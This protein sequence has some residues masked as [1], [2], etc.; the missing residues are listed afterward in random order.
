MTEEARQANANEA[1]KAGAG[2]FR[3]LSGKLLLLTIVFVMLAEVLIF[4]PSVA[5]MRIRWLE[6]RLNTAA[7]AAVVVDGLQ[8]VELPRSVQK[9]TLMATGTKAI[10]IR[11]KDASRMIAL[12]DMPLEIE[13]EYDVA[14]STAVAAI[15]DAFDTLLFGGDRVIRVYGP[16]GESDA[17]IELL[18]KDASLRKAM[19]VYSRNVFV[20]SL[21]ISLITAALIFL[22]INRML[23]TPIR[24]MTA[25]MQE[26]SNDP[27]DPGRVLVPPEG[28]DELAVAGQHLASMQRELQKTLKQQK[29]LAELGLAVSKINHDMRNI[30]SS[31]QLISDR[32][33]DVDDPV[34]K[35]FAPTLLRTIDRAVGYTREVLSYGRTTE[36]EP[37]RRF[38][39]L[40]PLV[41]DV[42]ELLAIDPQSGIDFQ[43]QMQDDLEVDADSEQLFRVVHNIC[44][45]AVQALTSHETEDG[46]PRI[47]AVSAM[48]IG[49]VVTISVDDTGPGMPPKA[50]ENLF[51]AFRGSARSGGT[52]LGLAIARELVLA[53]GGTIALVEKPT[54]GTLFRIELPDRPVP[55]DAFRSKLRH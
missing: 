47:V 16:L 14:N 20:L 35:R 41:S 4:V 29:S 48:R 3:G 10:V 28:R 1:L 30:L 13:G 42:A 36:A 49:S 31:A 17:T 32:L 52:G 21:I 33:A 11:R 5:T 23:I 45:N 54:P 39:A 12:T 9:D 46:R 24:R 26:F 53:H 37:H 25:N 2:F 50:R 44:R 22:A 6:D 51:A 40:K 15:R 8:N 7:A 34:V 18:M 19:L 43:I 27:A 38:V 55:L